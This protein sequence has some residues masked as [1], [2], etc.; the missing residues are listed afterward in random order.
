MS[1]CGSKIPPVVHT[2]PQSPCSLEATPNLGP[3]HP[4]VYPTDPLWLGTMCFVRQARLNR[5][6]KK[7]L[8]Y[9]ETQFIYA[10]VQ[11]AAGGGSLQL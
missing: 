10:S 1:N 8:K 11:T 6:L 2:S 4:D 7:K 5:E 3:H 9:P